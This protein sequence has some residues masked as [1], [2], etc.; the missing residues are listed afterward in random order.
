MAQ[1]RIHPNQLHARFMYEMNRKPWFE[2][3]ERL[4]SERIQ[5]KSR[6]LLTALCPSSPL[7]LL[8]SLEPSSLSHRSRGRHYVP[9]ISSAMSWKDALRVNGFT[10][11]SLAHSVPYLDCGSP[12]SRSL[13]Y[14]PRLPVGSP[15]WNP[16]L[17]M[18]GSPDVPRS[19]VL[20]V[21]L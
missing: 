2:A 16:S 3:Y 15:V 5:T 6:S 21:S 12:R 11:L 18:P 8:G 10:P 14:P 1:R 20:L 7:W 13:S 4:F 17:C 9:I 19:L